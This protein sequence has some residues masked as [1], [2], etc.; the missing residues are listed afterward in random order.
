MKQFFVLLAQALPAALVAGVAM[1]QPAGERVEG[2]LMG[3][4]MDQQTL[5]E[6]RRIDLRSAIESHRRNQENDAAAARRLSPEE[7]AE[8]RE[9]LRRQYSGPRGNPNA[10]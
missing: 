9:L 7:R 4:P 10:P 6:Q 2:V 8:M 5:K 1:A 3:K